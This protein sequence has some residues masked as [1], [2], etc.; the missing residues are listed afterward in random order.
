MSLHRPCPRPRSC[1]ARAHSGARHLPIAALLLLLAAA[2]ASGQE[3]GSRNQNSQEEDEK[4]LPLEPARS[5]TF[6]ADRGTWMSLDVSPDGAT[7][8]FD[9]LG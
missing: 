5:L 8:V 7:I 1:P 9:H 3:A 2:T 6:T 4:G